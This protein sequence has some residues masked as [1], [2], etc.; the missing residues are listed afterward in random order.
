MAKDPR[1]TESDQLPPFEQSLEQLEKIVQD[2]EGGQVSLEQ[3]IEQYERGMKL[4][5][6]CRSILE[7]V[8]TRIKSLTTD[9]KGTLVE[10]D[11][12]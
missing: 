7:R 1:K 12:P 2:I 6:H 9:E 3:S 10:K 4:V 5:K 8:E 11:T